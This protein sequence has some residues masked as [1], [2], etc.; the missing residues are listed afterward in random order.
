MGACEVLNL[1]LKIFR[2]QLFN[3]EA[4]LLF[5]PYMIKLQLEKRIKCMHKI[6]L[7]AGFC[8]LKMEGTFFSENLDS[9]SP[10]AP[11]G[12]VHFHRVMI[13]WG[14]VMVPD[15]FLTNVTSIWWQKQF[16]KTGPIIT[17]TSQYTQSS[18][19]LLEVY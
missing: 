7:P 4:L 15:I 3:S 13:E 2:Y 10:H 1:I 11:M 16:T 5:R 9:G 8:S 19:L 12:Q 14:L 18:I 17:A 6:S